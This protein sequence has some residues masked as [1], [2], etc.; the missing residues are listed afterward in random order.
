MTIKTYVLDA[1]GKFYTKLKTTYV[2]NCTSTDDDLPL[3][4]SQGKVLQDQI[5]DLEDVPER[6]DAVEDKTFSMDRQ[7]NHTYFNNA[8][9]DVPNGY[10][11]AGS[12]STAGEARVNCLT[13][14]RCLRLAATSSSNRAGIYDSTAER[15]GGTGDWLIMSDSDKTVVIPHKLLAYAYNLVGQRPVIVTELPGNA[16]H[17]LSI[18]ITGNNTVTFQGLWGTSSYSNKTLTLGT[19]DSRLKENIEPNTKS[20]LALINA[21]EVKQFD[22]K[23]GQG[24]W[25]Y[26]IIAQEARKIDPNLVIGEENEDSYLSIDTLYL[27]NTLVKAV[28]ELTFEV[29]KLKAEV[30]AL[31]N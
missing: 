1:L 27:A 12:Y 19:S 4:A 17:T 15:T 21:L 11:F 16:N 20:G 24:H 6:L 10:I 18:I 14:G 30:E 29:E 25:D 9:V 31:K 3:A 8:H 7:D 23:D 22:W 13:S 26:G 28:Q 2:T 5:D